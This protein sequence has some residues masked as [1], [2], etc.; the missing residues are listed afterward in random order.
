VNYSSVPL[1]TVN[2]DLLLTVDDAIERLAVTEPLDSMALVTGDPD[3][4]I[5]Y[6]K[7]W[8]EDVA[9]TDPARVW[10]D[11]P[12]QG[13]VQLTYQAARQLGST[14][15][16][17]QRFQEFLPPDLLRDI[18]RWALNYGLGENKLKLM[19]AGTGVDPSGAEV[20]LVVAQTRATVTPF[21]NIR[22]LQAVL[23]TV[24]GQ[25]GSEVADS[26]RIDYKFW[27][28]L[29]H[30]SVRVIFPA[31]QQVIDGTSTED[32]AWCYGIEFSNSLIGLKQTLVNGYLFRFICTNGARDVEH[33][34]G[35]FQRRGS[36]PEGAY[37]WAAESTAAILGGLDEAFAAVQ[38]LTRHPVDSGGSVVLAQLFRE[39]YVP[40]EQQAQIAQAMETETGP[41]TMYDVMQATT[42]AANIP[43]L[44]WRP[45]MALMALGGYIAH[46]GGGLCDG[47]LPHGCRRLLPED[48]KDPLAATE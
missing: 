7:G 29:E 41:L 26:A 16:I 31:A 34:S 22:L 42:R 33:A 43:G 28:D 21:S 35:G 10:L 11:V 5:T 9:P 12:G 2:D 44:S 24:R 25:L 36:T 46:S 38:E 37:T 15:R 4:D 23:D 48:W 1:D 19:T 45:A 13:Q 39:N 20:P 14:C 40:K 32:D 30:T 6:D 27:H 17:N 8:F 47:S 3:I 18:A